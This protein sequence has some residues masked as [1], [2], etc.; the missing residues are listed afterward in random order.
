MFPD[1]FPVEVARGVTGG[2]QP[3]THN[4]R[5]ENVTDPSCADG[6]RFMVDTARFYHAHRDWLF[7]G[8]MLDPG[9]MDCARAEVKFLNRGTYTKKGEY[10]VSTHELPTV[11]HSVWR[12]RKGEVGAVV[13]NW[14]GEIRKYRLVASDITGEGALPPR[15]WR[16]VRAAER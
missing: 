4:F 12:S 8:E 2:L 14:S 1:Q 15:S 13:V 9:V 6:Y 16:F 11:F 7:D 3:T 5:M 10:S